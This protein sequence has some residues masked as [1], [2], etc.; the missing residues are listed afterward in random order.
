MLKKG[1]IFFVVLCVAGAAGYFIYTQNIFSGE[2]TKKIK[3]T[4]TI[5]AGYKNTDDSDEE[6]EGF[7]DL[8]RE[9]PKN[10]SE[11]DEQTTVF[12][13]EKALNE[14]KDWLDD[15]E[16]IVMG[17]FKKIL[18]INSAL[19]LEEDS[20]KTYSKEQNAALFALTK[21]P[22]EV[23]AS[24]IKEE[25]ERELPEADPNEETEVHIGSAYTRKIIGIEAL[26]QFDAD[27]V[28]GL[29]EDAQ[30]NEAVRMFA[31][32]AHM[33]TATNPDEAAR[34]VAEYLD[35]EDDLAFV[36]SFKKKL[37]AGKE[38]EAAMSK[39]NAKTTGKPRRVK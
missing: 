5:K 28:L 38:K 8:L 13:N 37:K 11:I 22:L 14:L 6:F 19:D 2:K 17:H 10:E 32:R 26:A 35:N 36:R 21:L 15:D 27:Y 29:I 1:I 24:L 9:L 39:G 23:T 34:Y 30:T 25:I 20:P 16:A 4:E 33:Q 3:E 12:Y 7:L 18:E 31:V